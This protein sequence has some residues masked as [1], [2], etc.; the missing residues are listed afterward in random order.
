[1]TTAD[2]TGPKKSRCAK[3]KKRDHKR[4]RWITRG[5]DCGCCCPW[6]EADMWQRFPSLRA[7]A[8]EENE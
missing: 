1:M 5:V 8:L 3:C 7:I 4:C 6:L 2:D